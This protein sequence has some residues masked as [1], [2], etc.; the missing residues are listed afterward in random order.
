MLLMLMRLK[1]C[2]SIPTHGALGVLLCKDQFL[3][4]KRLASV[5]CDPEKV[6]KCKTTLKA[7]CKTNRNSSVIGS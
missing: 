6:W 7:R 2:F 4:S 5:S 3:F 1:I